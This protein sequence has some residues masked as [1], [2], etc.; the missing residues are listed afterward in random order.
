MPILRG[1]YFAC[2]GAAE[3]LNPPRIMNDLGLMQGLPLG[4]IGRKL[5]QR[6]QL[7]DSGGI[8]GWVRG[9]GD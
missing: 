8:L 4:F 3:P 6:V 2:E 5:C 7:A 9:R 1:P